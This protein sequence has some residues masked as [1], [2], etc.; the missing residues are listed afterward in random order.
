MATSGGC[1]IS[2]PRGRPPR[3]PAVT[4]SPRQL[5]SM[6]VLALLIGLHGVSW[7]MPLPEALSTRRPTPLSGVRAR[8][9]SSKEFF[10]GREGAKGI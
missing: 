4:F 5:G 7:N 8:P 3:R 9:T 1:E 10:P 6:D 2:L